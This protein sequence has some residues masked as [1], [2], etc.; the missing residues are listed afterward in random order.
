MIISECKSQSASF[1]ILE[2][3]APSLCPEKTIFVPEKIKIVLDRIFFVLDKIVSP[4][5]KAHIC[6]GK[7]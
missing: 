5:L 3:Y 7:G 4:G 6:F 2:S 1:V